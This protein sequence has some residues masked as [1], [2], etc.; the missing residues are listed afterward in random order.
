MLFKKI[1]TV[2]GRLHCYTNMQSVVIQTQRDLSNPTTVG[3]KVGFCRSRNITTCARLHTV[4]VPYL[5]LMT[6]ATRSR[7]AIVLLPQT[8]R[9]EI[10]IWHLPPPV[11]ALLTPPSLLPHVG[12]HVRWHQPITSHSASTSKAETQIWPYISGRAWDFSINVCASQ[13]PFCDARESVLTAWRGSDRAERTRPSQLRGWDWNPCR[14]R[15]TERCP[16]S[17]VLNLR[18]RPCDRWRRARLRDSSDK[19]GEGEEESNSKAAQRLYVCGFE[20]G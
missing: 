16:P 7:F 19:E 3:E 9:H 17:V 5:D 11:C 4:R 1:A 13:G 8:T 2:I 14:C 18:T 6:Y 12:W 20:A 15:Q 10:L